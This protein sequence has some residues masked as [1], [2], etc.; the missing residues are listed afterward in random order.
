MRESGFRDDKQMQQRVVITGMGVVSPI[1]T[2]VEEFFSSLVNGVSGVDEVFL[3][4]A[5]TFPVRIAAQVRDFSPQEYLDD[6]PEGALRERKTAMGLVAAK[7]AYHDAGLESRDYSPLRFGVGFGVGLEEFFMQDVIP[8]VAGEKVD[9]SQL[10][11]FLDEKAPP[12]RIKS[13]VDQTTDLIAGMFDAQGPRY[14]NVSACTAGAQAIGHAFHLIRSDEADVF[15]AGGCDSMVNPIG[16][17]RFAMLGALSMSN[18]LGAHASRPF[19]RLRDGMVMGEGAAAVVLEKL[20]YAKL[21]NARIYGE[22]TGYG[23]S[24]DAYRVTAPHPDGRGAVLAMKAALG[25]AGI[26]ASSVD[27]INAHGTATPLND[28]AETI[29]IKTVFGDYAYQIPVSSSKSMIGHSIA[30]AGALE[31][32]AAVTCIHTGVI[33]PT[34]NLTDPDPLCDLDYI[35]QVAREADVRVALSNSFGLGGQNATLIG[36][37][38]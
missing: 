10:L 5:S 32:A 27:Y 18:D 7:L 25:D 8:A 14:T 23:S 38:L 3:F 2:G 11:H 17:G 31:F 12:F 1:G 30:A 6:M 35:P 15:I 37:K 26:D 9:V 29:A 36:K 24:L 34:I 13:P 21:R 4:D 28:V 19:D 16:V 22:I 33:P 20:E